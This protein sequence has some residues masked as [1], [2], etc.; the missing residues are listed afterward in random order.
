MIACRLQRL[1]RLSLLAP[2]LLCLSHYPAEASELSVAISGFRQPHGVALVAVCDSTTYLTAGCP[3]RVRA[4]VNG[5]TA[6]V[7][8]EGLP[9]G[10]YAVQAV[11][12]ENGNGVLDRNGLGI[13]EEGYGFSRNPPTLFGPP[14]FEEAAISIGDGAFGTEINLR[15]LFD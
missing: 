4:P 13:P 2:I 15:Y 5:G 7:V 3:H 12:D 14:D 11:H 10:I 1:R 8:L 6:N 9:P